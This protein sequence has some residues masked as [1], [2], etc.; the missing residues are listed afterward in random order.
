MKTVFHTFLGLCAIA[1]ALALLFQGFM[2]PALGSSLSILLRIILG[3]TSQ[4]LFI[5]IFQRPVTKAIPTMISLG[6]AFWGF[7]LLLT[8]PSWLGVTFGIFFRDY[9]TFLVG[10]L[11]VLI[12]SRFLP[13]L[14]QLIITIIRRNLKT[15]PR[16]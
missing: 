13:W 3:I 10:C 12:M 11:I 2:F 4:W 8:S 7:F 1:C 16:K 6:I 14:W 15:R 9:A 5:S